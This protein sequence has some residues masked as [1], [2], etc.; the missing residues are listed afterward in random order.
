M[1]KRLISELP[2]SIKF[3]VKLDP[4]QPPPDEEN[5][6]PASKFNDGFELAKHIINP[7]TGLNLIEQMRKDGLFGLSP[8]QDIERLIEAR[9]DEKGL[10]MNASFKYNQPEIRTWNID[11]YN[12]EIRLFEDELKSKNPQDSEFTCYRQYIDYC[13]DQLSRLSKPGKDW[14]DVH[15][16]LI[17]GKYIKNVSLHDFNEV[18]ND[19]RLPNGKEKIMWIVEPK[20]WAVFFADSYGFTL[21]IFNNCFIYKDG[22]PFTR[23]NK[24]TAYPKNEFL[25][26]CKS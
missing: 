6:S 8:S 19:K 23:G 26:L 9:E 3:M 1:K 4:K 22:K 18:M 10:K 21:K 7:E 16:G 13:K 24:P 14:K 2:G 25:N 11:Y 5:T 12:N 17:N 15:L 20:T